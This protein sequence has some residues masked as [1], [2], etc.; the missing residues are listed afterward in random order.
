MFEPR[1]R[2]DPDPWG[3]LSDPV[4]L[5]KAD[6]AIAACGAGPFS[7]AC[8]LGAGVGGL[9]A[10]LAPRCGELIAIDAAPTA[11]ALA[12]ERL[13]SWPHARAVVGEIP[14]DL[15]AGPFELVVASE[16]LYYLDAGGFARTLRWL[17]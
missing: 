13:G 7:R 17:G 16:I 4:E 9:T 5:A 2:A 10:R 15:P 12:A 6:D 8:E 14:R 1:Y 11:V 3:T